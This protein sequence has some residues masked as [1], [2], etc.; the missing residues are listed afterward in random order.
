[1]DRYILLNPSGNITALVNNIRVPKEKYKEISGR[2]ME[3]NRAVE[4]VGFLK[5]LKP[6]Y[7]FR[8]EMAGGEFCGNASRAFACYLYKEKFIGTKRFQISV[9]GYPDLIDCKVD[10][11]GEHYFSEV[12]LKFRKPIS[13]FIENKTLNNQKISVVHIPGI[14]HIFLDINLFKFDIENYS[15]Q[16]KSIIQKLNLLNLPAVGVVWFDDRQI[17]PV[18]YVKDIDTLF[19]ENS[20]GSGSIAYG[21]YQVYLDN[22]DGL[23]SYDVIQK[24]REVVKVTI[25]LKDKIITHAKLYGETKFSL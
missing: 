11:K 8:L 15:G 4:Q 6:E 18:V 10:R 17:H 14:S 22:Q 19:Y 9:S 20:C 12:D 5:I 16:A 1:M 25:E 21:I 23:F 7:K 2:I 24:N 3:N 13:N